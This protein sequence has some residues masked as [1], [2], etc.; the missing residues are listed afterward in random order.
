MT[1]PCCCEASWRGCD[2][3][4]LVV[5]TDPTTQSGPMEAPNNTNES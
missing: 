5:H 2:G 1:K 4:R 3:F